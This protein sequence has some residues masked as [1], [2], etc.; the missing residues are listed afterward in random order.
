MKVKNMN[1]LLFKAFLVAVV[2]LFE[3]SFSAAARDEKIDPVKLADQLKALEQ[4]AGLFPVENKTPEDLRK[5]LRAFSQ[6]ERPAPDKPEFG[7]GW[8]REVYSNVGEYFA[9]QVS[10][11]FFEGKLAHFEIKCLK[12]YS[13]WDVV[14]KDV[15]KKW[16]D[17]G[18]P[19]YT[20]GQ[21]EIHYSTSNEALIGNY[22]AAVAS[23]LGEIPPRTVP[24]ELLNDYNL[25]ISP[26]ELGTI[27]DACGDGAV[28]SPQRLAILKLVKAGRY[29][30]I[31][32]VLRG[33]SPSGR[34]YALISLEIAR[35]KGIKLPVSTSEIM[36]KVEALPLLF[37]ICRGCI[38]TEN[39]SPSQVKA[40]LL[41]H[42]Q[43]YEK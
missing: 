11:F 34:V 20:V 14:G 35:K 36:E 43:F 10:V 16:K 4:V 8:T 5:G 31:S 21:T 42:F 3:M 37:K 22:Q 28:R 32:D 17:V 40:A 6:R 13:Q 2:I 12:W 39:L 24:L 33:F 1:R 7:F 41:R 29:D 25:L 15:L 38:G 30:L 27:G 18:L 9:L 23:K 19:D 26:F